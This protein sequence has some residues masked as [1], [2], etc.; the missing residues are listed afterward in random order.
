MVNK[1]KFLAS[2]KESG[3]TQEELADESNVS[4]ATIS[5]IIKDGQCSIQTAQRL[6]KAMNLSSERA[7]E[8]FFAELVAEMRH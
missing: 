1:N 4:R 6:S 5:R 2:M 7:G 8:I 3:F